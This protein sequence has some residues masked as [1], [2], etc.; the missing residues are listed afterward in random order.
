MKQVLQNQKTGEVKAT[1]IPV[2]VAR[3]GFVL[4]RTKASLI[5]AGTERATVEA[6]QKGLLARA[7]QQPHLVGQ[8]IQ[9]AKSDGIRNT[10]EAVRSKLGSLTAL[11]YSAAGNRIEGGDEV[12][13]LYIRGRRCRARG[14]P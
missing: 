8:V 2:P 6:G 11:G 14:G 5:S 1:D 3:P 9:R 12:G 13:K 7:V 4:V 10:V